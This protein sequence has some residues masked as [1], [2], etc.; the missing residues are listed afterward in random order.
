MNTLEVVDTIRQKFAVTGNPTKIPLLKGDV[1]TAEL[2][3]DGIRVD[4]LGN[5][6]FLPWAVFQEVICVLIRNDG[7]ADRGNAMGPRLGDPDLSFDSIEGHVA[8]VVY[9]KK[10]GDAIFRRVTPIACILI[11]A[12]IC[13][14]APGQLI[15]RNKKPA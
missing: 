7:V 13:E 5:Q 8:N 2:E 6:P 12:G 1:F 4:N 9:G 3:W 10:S 11:W 15:L 14:E